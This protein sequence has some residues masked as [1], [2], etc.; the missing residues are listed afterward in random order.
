MKERLNFR[1]VGLCILLSALLLAPAAKSK[2]SIDIGEKLKEQKIKI[3]KQLKLAPEK[4]K[5]AIELEENYSVKQKQIIEG[6][7]KSLDELQAEL[8]E[9][10]P[11]EAKVQELVKTLTTSQDN[12]F[13]SF[14]EQRDE[15]MAL[16]SPVEEGKY[17]LAL[18]KWRQEMMEEYKEKA[19]QKKKK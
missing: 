13:A 2:E 18:G 12:L 5:A 17:L 9:A 15:Q 14:K 3:I 8:K 6:M 1:L 16:M 7:K 11:D 4:E 10:K 19:P